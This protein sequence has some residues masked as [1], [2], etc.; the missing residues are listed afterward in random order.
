[1]QKTDSTEN[2][3]VELLQKGDSSSFTKLYDAYSGALFNII[4][5]ITLDN[6][7][8]ED[9]LQESF[10]KIWEKRLTYSPDKGRIFTWMLNI[11]RNTAI[12]AI[13][14]KHVKAS[15][16][17]Q[18]IEDNV[19][20]VNAGNKTTISTDTIGMNEMVSALNQDQ[21]K[22]IQLAYFQGY[23]QEEVA[24]KLNIPIGTV[25]TRTRAALQLLRKT[26]NK[27]IE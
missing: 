21:Q 26:F 11:A 12:D 9:V 8:S 14:N 1:M 5:K 23:T 7:L 24:E 22:I 20:K 25:K 17:I 3:M 16:K 18:N 15:S 10:V 19:H 13:R 6:Q 27:G 2:T 4:S